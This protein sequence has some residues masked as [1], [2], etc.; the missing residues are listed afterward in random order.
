MRRRRQPRGARSHG[1]SRSA[2][3]RRRWW[4]AAAGI[5]AAITAGIWFALPNTMPTPE[6]P[7]SS[8]LPLSD[9]ALAG[10]V[11]FDRS[12]AECHGPGAVGSAKG[13]PLIHRVYHPGH[14]GDVAFELAVR[15]GVRA[16]HWQ[17]GDM[18][19]QPSVTPTEVVE[20]T[21]YVRERQRAS[22]IY[23]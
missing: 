16:H 5:V 4:F 14:H 11:L 12:C 23:R 8:A 7:A 6:V 10:K 17:F 2:W 20:I 21:R 9:T 22:G 15:R 19:P 1:G 3:T 18:A 13:P